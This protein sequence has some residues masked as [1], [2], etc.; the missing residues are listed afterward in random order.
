MNNET[1]RGGL[2][3]ESMGVVE[4]SVETF[5]AQID[6]VSDELSNR[7]GGKKEHYYKIASIVL[8]RRYQQQ[9][10][11]LAEEVN[12]LVGE[13]LGLIDK[14]RRE[15]ETTANVNSGG[16]V[17]EGFH[18]EIPEGYE[19]GEIDLD[20][21][22]LTSV[23][24]RAHLK[25]DEYIVEREEYTLGQT[26][27][28][29]DILYG[30]LDNSERPANSPH[31]ATWDV[32]EWRHASFSVDNSKA[33]TVQ[34][35]WLLDEDAWQDFVNIQNDDDAIGFIE[36]QPL[37]GKKIAEIG[38]DQTSVLMRLGAE[39]DNTVTIRAKQPDQSVSNINLDNWRD[40]YEGDYDLVF[41][42]MVMDRGTGIDE[43]RGIY[44]D[45]TQAACWEMHVTCSAML[46]MGG[47]AIHITGNV[48]IDAPEN[49][50]FVSK[51]LE[52]GSDLIGLDLGHLSTS[53]LHEVWSRYITKPLR[54]VNELAPYC[55]LGPDD[56]FRS[57][58]GLV[59]VISGC[60][61]QQGGR[62]FAGPLAVYCKVAPCEYTASNLKD[63]AVNQSQVIT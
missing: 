21:P 56:I 49:V 59:P 42:S 63:L 32:S 36:K 40:Y 7:Y 41:T 35:Q 30:L 23:I 34:L 15:Y 24:D 6:G 10:V 26:R 29:A 14:L 37:R 28:S 9:G 22:E 25:P 39:V 46:R 44:T 17:N 16:S 38:G 13:S 1:E 61:W 48:G 58:L 2:N 11:A 3:P 31:P 50:G 55:R 27:Q 54:G 47:M 18:I 8:Y 19:R 4:V 57:K 12:L 33:M 52:T 5:T 53:Y 43:M 62:S 45:N 51:M 20:Y 60:T